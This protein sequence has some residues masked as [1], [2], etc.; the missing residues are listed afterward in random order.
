MQVIA[1][2]LRIH[3]F[4][5]PELLQENVRLEQIHMTLVS[6]TSKNPSIAH[7]V[8]SNVLKYELVECAKCYGFYQSY[9]C[10]ICTFLST[11]RCA[12]ASQSYM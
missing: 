6:F 12:L 9:A 3:L 4:G 2:Q 11:G 1:E 10:F 8:L 5:R 7:A